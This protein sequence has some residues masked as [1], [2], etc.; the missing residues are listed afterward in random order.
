MKRSIGTKVLSVLIILGVIF[1][2]GI[3][4]NVAALQTIDGYNKQLVNVYLKMENME[5]ELDAGFQEVQLYA[6][7]VYTKRGTNQQETMK[8]DF[9]TALADF[10]GS[11][12]QLTQ[13]TSQT[14]DKQLI[15]ACESLASAAGS[16]SE[17]MGQ[18][19]TAVKSGDYDTA[20][21][22]IDN[23]LS[24]REPVVNAFNTYNE[25]S[26]ASVTTLGN[27][28]TLKIE[29]TITFDFMFVALF[30]LVFVIAVVVVRRTI[31]G[32]AKR[33]EKILKDIVEKI[34]QNEGDLTERIPVTSSDEIGQMSA[35]INGFIEQLQNIMQKLREESL[36]LNG[37]V[38][39]VMREIDESNES[40]SNVSAA[41]EQMSASLEEISA[42]LGSIVNGSGEVMSDIERMNDRMGDG[43]ELVRQ[44]KNRAGDMH[45]ST[46]ESKAS[47][48][49]VIADIRG[50]LQ[51]ALEESR[52]VEKI[53]DLTGDILSITSQTNLLSL[54]ASIEAARAGEAGRGFA[55]VADE[56]RVLADN[57]A[58]T[59]G[60]IQNISNQVTGAVE[61]LAKNAEEMLRF[62]D[63]K[64]MKD[65]DGFVDIV[66]QYEQD[67]DSVDEILDE[68]A[69]NTAQISGTM[70][71]M[72][73]GLNGIATAVDE[74]AKG[75]TNVAESAVSLV[76]A[77]TQI[78][79]AT[80]TNQE[81]SSKLSGEVGRFKNV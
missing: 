63:E 43:V 20:G 34:E 4:A 54:N 28:S 24:Y 44:I 74:S 14:G 41:M 15:A 10:N 55:V 13:L 79:Q 21:P 73:D 16:F 1:G 52:S 76:D 49:Q 38:E 36:N 56:I 46:A 7:L 72:S 70:E 75:V 35:G 18:I 64:V 68:F 59:A 53:N 40:A 12:E 71:R 26:V 81:I 80:E 19:L 61:R 37:S 45:R 48:V 29:G 69:Q 25:M 22:L 11:M 31:A 67:A 23:I 2:L 78:H 50:K 62:I 39:A 8:T 58:D 77:I 60:N 27:R 17:Y 47:A 33:S 57:S 3:V 6:N 30:V 9:E 66:E 65:Y 5:G 42:T 51:A 32:P